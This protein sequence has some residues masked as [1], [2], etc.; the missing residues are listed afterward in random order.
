MRRW[1]PVVLIV[2]LMTACSDK[3]K[4]QPSDA[5]QRQIE[6]EHQKAMDQQKQLTSGEGDSMLRDEPQPNQN[7]KQQQKRSKPNTQQKPA[8]QTKSSS[9]Q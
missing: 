4:D 6:Q 5:Q 9:Q 3:G 1:L 2:P 7:T 8:K